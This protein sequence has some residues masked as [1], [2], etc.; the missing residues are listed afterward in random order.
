MVLQDDSFSTIV[1]AVKQGRI[2]FANIRKFVLY[3]LS[4]NLSEILTV[5][6]ASFFAVP[7]P[8]LPLQILF[9]NLVTGVFPALAL[10]AGTGTPGVMKQPARDPKEPV[11][12]RRHW[13]I[14][15][16][17]SMLISA[18]V[19]IALFLSLFVLDFGEGKAVSVSFLT[20]AFAQ[21][22]HV[23][24]MRER[25]SDMFRND[26]T[27]N[28][29]IW[30][31]LLLCVILLLSAAYLPGLSTILEMMPPDIGGWLL[32][33]GLSLVPLIV[34]QPLKYF[35]RDKARLF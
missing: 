11:I 20:L 9:L 16:A 14:M 6:I 21:L 28:P 24:N 19:L 12:G 27:R 25:G 5:G 15:S 29:W 4:C 8:L 10:G 31:A 7:L 23:F 3:L 17:Y 18:S 30:G 1:S 22:W 33:I 32:V 26:I 35:L 13:L 34:V 2:I